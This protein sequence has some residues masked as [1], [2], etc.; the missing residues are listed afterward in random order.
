VSYIEQIERKGDEEEEEWMMGRIYSAM[1]RFFP[2]I[3]DVY[4][5]WRVVYFLDIVNE[6]S[7]SHAQS[8]PFNMS[9]EYYL[10]TFKT[11]KFK[12]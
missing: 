7:S 12:H 3:Q 1:K 8:I 10:K 5:I 6:E 4:C 11:L 9:L 2:Y